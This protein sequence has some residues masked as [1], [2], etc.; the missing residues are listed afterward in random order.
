MFR[1]LRELQLLRASVCAACAA[2]GL[3]EPRPPFFGVLLRSVVSRVGIWR[4]RRLLAN[5]LLRIS[6]T[7]RRQACCFRTSPGA[8]PPGREVCSQLFQRC[9]FWSWAVRAAYAA[10]AV[11]IARE[12]GIRT[13]GI[14]TGRWGAGSGRGVAV[15]GFSWE[16][17]L[18][19]GRL[20]G[21]KATDCS[22]ERFVA[23]TGAGATTVLC[24]GKRL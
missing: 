1:L 6:R 20:L 7:S 13:L 9:G 12:I 14:I 4:R 15:A 17:K 24:A 22:A 11:E 8:S 2:V 5:R 3:S 23:V 10:A 18:C 21:L 19:A 16:S